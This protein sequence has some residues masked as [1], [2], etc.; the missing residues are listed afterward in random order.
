MRILVVEDETAMAR[1]LARGLQAEGYTV[2]VAGDGEEGL[3]RARA[4]EF[5]AV[6]LDLMLPKLNGTDVVA[7][8]RAVGARVPVLMLTAKQGEFDQTE[9]LDSGADDFLSKPFSYPVLLARLRALIRRGGA[10]QG[11]VLEYGD[12]RL[13][14]ANH[15][16]WRATDEISLTRRELAL[17]TYLF[18]RPEQ[19][20]SKAELLDHVWDP[21]AERDPNVVEVY[22]GYLRRKLDQPGRPSHV[23]TVRSLGYRLA[24]VQPE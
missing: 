8:L 4:E 1:S 13:D 16:V 15:R 24:L 6:I 3:A 23:E 11:A 12:L 22:V 10:A 5:D 20:V 7:E 18:H 19:A 9:A 14:T 21:A 2:D 17:L